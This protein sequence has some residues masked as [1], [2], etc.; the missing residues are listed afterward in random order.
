MVDERTIV[1][2]DDYVVKDLIAKDFSAVQYG[3]NARHANNHKW[4]YFPAMNRDEAII[5]KQMDSDWTKQSRICF[6]MSAHNPQVKNH[7]IRESIE[8]R[9]ICYWKVADSGVNSMPT[10]ENTNIDMIKDPEDFAEEMNRMSL[11]SPSNIF[12]LPFN[13]IMAMFQTSTFGKAKEYS[14]NPEDYLKPLVGAVNSFSWWPAS[15]K[16]WVHTTISSSESL[17]AGIKTI[18]KILVDDKENYAK[19]KAFKAIE[20]KAIVAFLMT[21]EKYLNA[22]K[23]KFVSSN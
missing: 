19:T 12:K 10:I 20:K 7:K 9:M 5:F 17:E 15:A 4:Y 18:T 16:S 23:E 2:P 21:N 11:S 13:I 1:K 14:G 22:A 8:L 6:H 3:L